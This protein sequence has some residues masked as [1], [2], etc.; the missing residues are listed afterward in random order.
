MSLRAELVALDDR[1]S[2][3]DMVSPFAITTGSWVCLERRGRYRGDLGL[4]KEVNLDH[5]STLVALVPRIRMTRKRDRRNRPK[6]TLF[7]VKAVQD[8]HGFATVEKRNAGWVFKDQ[9]YRSGLLELDFKLDQLSNVVPTETELDIFRQTRDPT[10]VSA[11]NN[12][13]VPL[14]ISEDIVVIAGP[15]QRLVGRVTGINRDGV[16]TFD[17]SDPAVPLQVH[18]RDVRKG[19]GLGDFVAVVHGE[20]HGSE[21][22]IVD[23]DEGSQ[24]TFIFKCHRI[25]ENVLEPLLGEEVSYVSIPNTTTYVIT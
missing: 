4:V 14:R 22:F 7:D 8:M 3:L 21:G 16:V 17:C 19:F 1:V 9:F 25:T 6:S 18:L 13:S 23:L 15:L 2:L 24:T 10:V 12:R 5:G 20:F 11:A